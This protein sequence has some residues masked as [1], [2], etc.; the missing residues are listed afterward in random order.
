MQKDKM[1]KKVHNASILA[2][3]KL[4]YYILDNAHDFD[5]EIPILIYICT[6][7]IMPKVQFWIIDSEFRNHEI[8]DI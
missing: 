6:R 7:I 2:K 4:R 8:C 5:F 3:T 1:E